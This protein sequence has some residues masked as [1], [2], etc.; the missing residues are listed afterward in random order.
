MRAVAARAF[1][2]R[3]PQFPA[4]AP[5]TQQERLLA[6]YVSATPVPE[7]LA[8]AA[9]QQAWRD[10]VQDSAEVIAPEPAGTG[11]IDRLQALPLE[12]D[13]T[14]AGALSTR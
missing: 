7:L 13:S 4:A 2:P 8:V 6:A 12:G 11:E 1:E 9:D 14:E 5:P 10:Q 3:Q